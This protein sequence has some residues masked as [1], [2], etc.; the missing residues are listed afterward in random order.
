MG[1]F[2]LRADLHIEVAG[3]RDSEEV[4]IRARGEDRQIRSPPS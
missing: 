4:A 3:V 2:S 1:P